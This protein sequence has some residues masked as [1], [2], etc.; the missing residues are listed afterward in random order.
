MTKIIYNES[1]KVDKPTYNLGD[2]FLLTHRSIGNEYLVL[3]SQTNADGINFLTVEGDC[4]TRVFNEIEVESVNNISEEDI[5][6]FDGIEKYIV[7]KVDVTITV[8][9]AAK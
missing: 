1:K 4:S 3:L 5:N 7:E 2:W 8:D 9:F 6:K